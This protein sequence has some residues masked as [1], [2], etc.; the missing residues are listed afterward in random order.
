[1]G[2]WSLKQLGEDCVCWFWEGT[3]GKIETCDTYERNCH[4]DCWVLNFSFERRAGRL[5]GIIDIQWF[6]C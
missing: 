5:R 1:M 2:L 6:E 4:L 3:N